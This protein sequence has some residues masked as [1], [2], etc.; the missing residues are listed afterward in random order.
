MNLQKEF[1]KVQIT[2]SEMKEKIFKTSGKGEDLF[3]SL[4]QRAFRGEL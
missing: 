1:K 3:S 2:H 4:T